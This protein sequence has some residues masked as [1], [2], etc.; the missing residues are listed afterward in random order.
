MMTE[1]LCGEEFFNQHKNDYTEADIATL[2]LEVSHNNK[3]FLNI[4]N[5]AKNKSSKIRGS[6]EIKRK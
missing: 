4:T 3:K 5:G 6:M 2:K 1:I